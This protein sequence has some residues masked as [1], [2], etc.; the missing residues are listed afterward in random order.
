M[1][2][3]ASKREAEADLPAD[4][5]HAAAAP[6]ADGPEGHLPPAAVAP[7]Q[8]QLSQRK[9]K[10]SALPAPAPVPR[11][12]AVKKRTVPTRAVLWSSLRKG[13]NEDKDA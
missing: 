8:R 2:G 7:E 9:K 6:P 13:G 4:A 12:P 3:V 5:A 10:K 11:K 1:A